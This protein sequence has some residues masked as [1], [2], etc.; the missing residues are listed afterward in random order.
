MLV[1]LWVQP[2]PAFATS[3]DIDHCIQALTDVNLDVARFDEVS[4][5]T[6]EKW[7]ELAEAALEDE[8]DQREFFRQIGTEIGV[9]LMLQM[10]DSAVHRI[11]EITN[12]ILEELW[13]DMQKSE[14]YQTPGYIL[15]FV[16]RSIG[17]HLDD[18]VEGFAAIR[19][20]FGP[21]TALL[22]AP[23]PAED[24][25]PGTAI[26]RENLRRFVQHKLSLLPGLEGGVLRY[27][28]GQVDGDEHSLEEAIFFFRAD[29]TSK[30]FTEAD[31]DLVEE[32][33]LRG[34]I[35]IRQKLSEYENY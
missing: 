13:T 16:Y 6:P 3:E 35:W 5:K 1:L 18:D 19:G 29:R 17:T 15:R 32:A 30:E 12:K 24:E 8:T 26:D 11:S 31:K 33:Y 22:R 34:M 10:G 20:E 21:S 27:M 7:I 23:V 9:A 4:Q 14:R 28:F 25:P 2:L